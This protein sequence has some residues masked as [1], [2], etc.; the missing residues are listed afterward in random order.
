M[1]YC[2]GIR[3]CRRGGPARLPRGPGRDRRSGSARRGARRP[4]RV[5]AAMNG[6]LSFKEEP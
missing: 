2:R 3:R 5:H 6:Q 4:P 1:L